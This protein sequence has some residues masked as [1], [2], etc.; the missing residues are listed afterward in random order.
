M[1]G[2]LFERAWI[3]LLLLL[4]SAFVMVQVWARRRSRAAATRVWIVLASAVVLPLLSVLVQT[5]RERIIDVCRALARSADAGDVPGL[6]V[7]FA[8]DF[9]AS[10]LDRE[11]LLARIE[12]SLLKYRVDAVELRGFEVT[13]RG[14]GAAAEFR[15]ACNVRSSEAFLDRVLSRWR[16]TFRRRDRQWMVTSIEALPMPRSPIHGLEAVLR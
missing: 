13:V 9:Q 3:L 1:A 7:H 15:A 16:L 14:E 5:P 6:A 11:T 12:Q 8:M 2:L 4:A 10:N